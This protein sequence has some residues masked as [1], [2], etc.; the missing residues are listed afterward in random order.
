MPGQ[1]AAP[2]LPEQR[3][4]RVAPQR[5]EWIEIP[6]VGLGAPA[7]DPEWNAETVA[8]WESWWN[9]PASTQWTAADVG[10]V[11]YLAKLFD[12]GSVTIA[13]EMRLRMD[14]LGLTQKG[15]RD[16]RWRV[17]EVEEEVEPKKPAKSRRRTLNVVA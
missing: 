10:S 16:M 7:P 8:A 4:N 12:L 13:N 5:G 11:R 14:G 17:V 6:N 9:D 15:K 3:R 1:G 2:K